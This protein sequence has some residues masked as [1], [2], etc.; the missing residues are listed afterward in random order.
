MP[1]L[2]FSLAVSILLSAPAFAEYEKSREMDWAQELSL[3]ETQQRQL[4]DIEEKYRLK[5][6]NTE[7]CTDKSARHHPLHQQRQAEIQRILSAE[8]AQ[9]AEQIMR[10]QHQR[11]QLQRV[12]ELAHHF[13]LDSAQ[14]EA[15]LAAVIELQADYQWP[16]DLAQQEQ[17]RARFDALTQQ[18]LSA[19]QWQQLQT[20]RK[21]SSKWHSPNEFKPHC[22]LMHKKSKPLEAIH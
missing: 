10:Q 11:V 4:H 20:H 1:H 21:E 12:K 14:K 18:H 15:F 13:K 16:L 17:A 5:F 19:A 22:T 2:F 8:Q 6:K 3:T 9:R 7:D